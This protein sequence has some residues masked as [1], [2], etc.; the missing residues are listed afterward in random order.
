MALGIRATLHSKGTLYFIYSRIRWWPFEICSKLLRGTPKFIVSPLIWKVISRKQSQAKLPSMLICVWVAVINNFR[1]HSQA[2]VDGKDFRYSFGW[3]TAC[4][5][6]KKKKNGWRNP[7]GPI[8]LSSC[9][10]LNSGQMLIITA[11]K[12]GNYE[13]PGRD[14]IWPEH[15]NCCTH[16]LRNVVLKFSALTAFDADHL[17]AQN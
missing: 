16:T 8:G 15:P 6:E 3:L 4:F 12:P 10:F 2:E 11:T 5:D 17:M 7:E 13:G 1:I 9:L 14:A